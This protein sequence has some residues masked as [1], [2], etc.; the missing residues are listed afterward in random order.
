[1]RTIDLLM[2]VNTNRC[3]GQ[4]IRYYV[5]GK[6]VSESVYENYTGRAIRQ[7]SF[8]TTFKNDVTRHYKTV[9]L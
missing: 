6:R 7:D 3:I 1:M 4:P 9:Y 8:M 5:R 2:V